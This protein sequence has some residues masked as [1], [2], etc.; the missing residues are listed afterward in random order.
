VL[1]I[2][3]SDR[4]HPGGPVGGTATKLSPLPHTAFQHVH[5][6]HVRFAESLITS[7]VYREAFAGE[8]N[9]LTAL[10]GLMQAE[11]MP[12]AHAWREHA[13]LKNGIKLFQVRAMPAGPEATFWSS[14]AVDL[15]R[16]RC[17]QA[18][19]C[20][21]SQDCRCYVTDRLGKDALELVVAWL[22][23]RD[24]RRN[25]RLL[26]IATNPAIADLCEKIL[27][28]GLALAARPA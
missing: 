10:A 7:A 21:T 17:R 22:K 19:P 4:R 16:D 18:Q 28:W 1:T 15:Q 3:D 6:L 13:E 23:P 9:K 11:T 20:T 25:A 12:S 24:P 2:V 14:V 26:G 5:V 27:A 8:R